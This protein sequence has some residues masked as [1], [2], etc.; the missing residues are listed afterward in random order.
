MPSNTASTASHPSLE[1]NVIT[2]QDFYSNYIPFL[3]TYK[4]FSLKSVKIKRRYAAPRSQSKYEHLRRFVD[5]LASLCDIEKRG[6]D[7]CTAV[8]LEALPNGR[9]EGEDGSGRVAVHVAA[10]T[11][12]HAEKIKALAGEV[13]DKLRMVSGKTENE[14]AIE[15]I[16]Q[17]S[18]GLYSCRVDGYIDAAR[19][20]LRELEDQVKPR[21]QF[22]IGKSIGLAERSSVLTA[23]FPL[24]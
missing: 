6:G 4:F 1:H 17:H 24:N 11:S 15:S 9:Y 12:Y 18:L 7:T 20:C 13:I 8:A 3:G 16:L 23:L 22:L 2:A 5:A 10:N 19:K 21:P 14:E